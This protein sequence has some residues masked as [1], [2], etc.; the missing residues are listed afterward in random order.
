MASSRASQITIG[1]KAT[2]LVLSLPDLIK[3]LE[4]L[5]F[6][7]YTPHDGLEERQKQS[8]SKS[9]SVTVE[10]FFRNDDA[11][12]EE[13]SIAAADLTRKCLF[14]K[15]RGLH[16]GRA[17]A[18]NSKCLLRDSSS[19]HIPMIDFK[20]SPSEDNLR[21]IKKSLK[22]KIQMRGVILVSGAS[23]HFYGFK[24]LKEDE[25]IKFLGRC[26]LEPSTDSRWIGHSIRLDTSCLR[27][28]ANEYK[29]KM[30]WV[31]CKV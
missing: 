1:T 4:I 12:N 22:E 6:T 17:L 13:W 27:I 10:E 26:L 24:T 20:P 19:K 7:I 31:C 11:I 23:Y 16:N 25:W 9:L 3:D 5:T 18:L 2:Q 30:P 29:Q 21:L 8:P 14:E 15:I 28:S